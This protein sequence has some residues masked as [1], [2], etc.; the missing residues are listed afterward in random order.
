MPNARLGCVDWVAPRSPRVRVGLAKDARR[1]LPAVPP[2]PVVLRVCPRLESG[3]LVV[4]LGCCSP[5]EATAAAH[6]L[7][8]PSNRDDA[9]SPNHHH[10][11][12]HH[13]HHHDDSSA[14]A[15]TAPLNQPSEDSTNGRCPAGEIQRQLRRRSYC[16]HDGIFAVDLNLGCP[17][18]AAMD[19]GSGVALFRDR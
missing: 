15:T 3:R 10:L 2:P 5:A 9:N 17:Q 11:N 18:R 6:A 1:P 19:G 7:F 12:H 16:P 4:Q 13:H 14:D 8:P